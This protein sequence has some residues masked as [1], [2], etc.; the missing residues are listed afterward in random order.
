[1]KKKITQLFVLVIVITCMGMFNS[2]KDYDEDNYN[3]LTLQ[4]RETS[5]L[6]QI[7]DQQREA[8]KKTVDSLRN[9]VDTLKQCNCSDERFNTLITNYYAANPQVDH[10]SVQTIIQEYLSTNPGLTKAQVKTMIDTTLTNYVKISA[11]NDTITV[12]NQK[13]SDLE[14]KMRTELN[15]SLTNLGTKMRAELKDSLLKV[16]T[17]LTKISITANTAKTFADSAL[18]LAQWDSLQIILLGDS[19]KKVAITASKAAQQAQINASEISVLKTAYNQLKANDSIQQAAIDSIKGVLNNFATKTDLKAVQDS[20]D[21]LYAKAIAYINAAVDTLISRGE[22]QDSLASIQAAF[23]AADSALQSQI[24]TLKSDLVALT[25]TVAKNT[26]DIATLKS[27]YDNVLKQMITS[28]VVQGAVNPVFGQFALP[29]GVRSNILVAYYGQFE[30]NIYFPTVAT[31]DM[32]YPDYAL[33]DKDAEMIG[34]D[35]MEQVFKNDANGYVINEKDYNAGKVYLTVNPNTAD[36]TG[37]Q[38]EM[39]NSLDAACPIALG[40][41]VPSTDKLTFGWTKATVNGQSTNA[42]YEAPANL[43]S[44]NIEAAKIDIEPGLKSTVKQALKEAKNQNYGSINFSNLAQKIYNQFDGILDANGVKGTWTDSLG[45]HSV[46]SE[47]ALAAAAVKPL[48]FAFLNDRKVGDAIINRLPKITPISSVNFSF[49]DITIDMS[50]VKVTVPTLN[51]D[52]VVDFEDISLDSLGDLVVTVNVPDTLTYNPVTGDITVK[53]TK[54][55]NVNLE[56][57]SE[58]IDNMVAILNQKV[59]RWGQQIEEGIEVQLK[60]QFNTAMKQLENNINKMIQDVAGQMNNSINSEMSK[61]ANS[62]NTDLN[63]N[64]ISKMNKYIN[65]LNSAIEKI[66]PILNNAN[67]YLQPALTYDN[68]NGTMSMLSASKKYPTPFIGTGAKAIYMTSYTAEILAPSYKKFVAITDVI[69]DGKSAK[70]GDPECLTEF[71]K[72]KAANKIQYNGIDNMYAVLDGD[73]KA[74]ALIVSSTGY[75]YEI[76]YSALDYSGKIATRKYY[77]KVQ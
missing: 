60:N 48:S 21:A 16:A 3:N 70:A 4:L 35:V 73:Q 34:A 71:S 5:N 41:L 59:A 64:Y 47:Y 24:D 49:S 44:D 75:T 17:E 1:M 14:T 23:Q 9:R 37:A 33:T 26:K 12:I 45:T 20:A 68:V 11:L 22:F 19:L 74:V 32:V 38:F 36:F 50:T 7:I 28:I 46:Y 13:I 15:D 25:N 77:V 43:T 66:R 55:E 76:A 53:T 72:V 6:A 62:I 58:W 52:I 69:K 30:H 27:T 54:K 40:T 65:K 39:V 2:C 61:I 29:I 57:Y 31:S 51:Y 42:F 8:L 63:D 56:N 67:Y 18:K 10:D